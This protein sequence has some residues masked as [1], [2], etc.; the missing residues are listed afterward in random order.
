[1]ALLSYKILMIKY[2]REIKTNSPKTKRM[3]MMN[4]RMS[5]KVSKRISKSLSKSISKR[6]N[7]KV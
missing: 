3:K 7:R 5:S 6:I 4:K 1:M 2:S